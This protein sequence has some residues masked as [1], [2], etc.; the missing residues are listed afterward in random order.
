MDSVRLFPLWEFRL[1]ASS[2]GYNTSLFFTFLFSNMLHNPWNS[3]SHQLPTEGLFYILVSHWTSTICPWMP[4]YD[5]PLSRFFF[6]N[7][8]SLC[9][10]SRHVLFAHR[11]YFR[12]RW[13]AVLLNTFDR[14]RLEWS[15]QNSKRVEGLENSKHYSVWTMWPW[16]TAN[17]LRF[18]NHNGGC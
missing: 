14:C 2:K 6:S 9:F 10:C 7:W 12:A 11:L 8:N 4:A 13:R 17:D 15:V 18:P 5:S 1:C 16:E 3:W